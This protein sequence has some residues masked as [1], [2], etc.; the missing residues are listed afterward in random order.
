MNVVCYVDDLQDTGKKLHAMLD[1]FLAKDQVLSCQTKEELTHWLLQ[2]A[3][4]VRAAVLFARDHYHLSMLL[5]LRD[6]LYDCR[7]ILVLPDRAPSTVAQGHTFR[8]RLLTFV[9]TDFIPMVGAVLQ[10]IQEGSCPQGCLQSP[11]PGVQ[12]V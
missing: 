10:H 5:S 11:E 12:N 2:P 1:S 4:D 8:P 3:Q 7:V 6:L 9:D